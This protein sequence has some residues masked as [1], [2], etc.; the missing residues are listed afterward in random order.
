[1]LIITMDGRSKI[2]DII[3]HF[4]LQLLNV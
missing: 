1:L 3:V 2:K 4:N